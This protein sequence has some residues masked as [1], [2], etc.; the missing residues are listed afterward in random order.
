MMRHKNTHSLLGGKSR[1]K[2]FSNNQYI[3]SGLLLLAFSVTASQ[4]TNLG[5]WKMEKN[6]CVTKK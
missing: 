1:A 2:S 5:T 4:K 3:A 6:F